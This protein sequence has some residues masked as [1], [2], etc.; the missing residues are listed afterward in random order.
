LLSNRADRKETIQK[1]QASQAKKREE[2]INSR[3]QAKK[4]KK[5]GVKASKSVGKSNPKKKGRPGFEG[6]GGGKRK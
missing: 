5:M 6:K 3:L 2:N 4:D 1:T